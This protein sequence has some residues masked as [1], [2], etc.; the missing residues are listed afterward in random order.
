[1]C[2]TSLTTIQQVISRRTEVH[3]ASQSHRCETPNRVSY[4]FSISRAFTFGCGQGS[5][6]ARVRLK[7][8]RNH[9]AACRAVSQP[10]RDSPAPRNGSARPAA[11]QLVGRPAHAAPHLLGREL[12]REGP[13]HNPLAVRVARHLGNQE[14]HG[15][16]EVHAQQRAPVLAEKRQ[17]DAQDR[18][19]S[20][21]VPQGVVLVLRRDD[22]IV[23]PFG[24]VRAVRRG[25]CHANG[26]R[27]PWVWI[28]RRPAG[29]VPAGAAPARRREAQYLKYAR[30]RGALVARF[31]RRVRP[32]PPVK[33]EVLL[34]LPPAVQDDVPHARHEG[35]GKLAGKEREEPGDEEVA[36]LQVDGLEVPPQLRIHFPQQGRQGVE[37]DP[38]EGHLRDE[39]AAEAA[40]LPVQQVAQRVEGFL[41]GHVHEAHGRQ[42]VHALAVPQLRVVSCVGLQHA[43]QREDARSAFHGSR[44]HP[45]CATGRHG[46]P[47]ALVA[48][49]RADPTQAGVLLVAIVLLRPVH[50]E[51]VVLRKCPIDVSVNLLSH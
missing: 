16:G 8:L 19:V 48:V 29:V 18:L 30:P 25:G 49:F 44:E 33:P 38:R 15:V 4:P 35:E 27:P 46:P 11:A 14:D 2:P 13:F 36:D 1:M 45:A 3:D 37:H 47:A 42:V 39:Q 21:H 7:P 32:R 22:G 10:A 17:T 51:H 24:R 23:L 50:P 6:A 12:H 28:G 43:P 34:R 5:A 40:V 41:L 31:A 20:T 9:I 26:G